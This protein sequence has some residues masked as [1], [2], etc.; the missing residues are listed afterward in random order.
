M[1]RITRI[2]ANT[3]V[4][5]IVLALISIAKI[6]YLQKKNTYSDLLRAKWSCA[7]HEMRDE[8]SEHTELDFT[9]Y[10]LVMRRTYILI[11]IFGNT[12][13]D[14]SNDFKP[15]LTTIVYGYNKIHTVSLD[16]TQFL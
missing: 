8:M 4:M 3:Y 5:N 1:V 15:V 9:N 13:F 7:I 16:L 12:P 11:A 10:T 14:I 6:T 2:K